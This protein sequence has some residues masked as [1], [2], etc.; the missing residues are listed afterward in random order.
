MIA[1]SLDFLIQR[2]VREVYVLLFVFL[3]QVSV[4]Q[5]DKLTSQVLAIYKC[6]YRHAV[7]KD[8][9]RL[10]LLLLLSALKIYSRL[11]LF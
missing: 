3:N 10:F 5:A 1:N 9:F 6:A 2:S 11:G 7:T 4:T 8:L